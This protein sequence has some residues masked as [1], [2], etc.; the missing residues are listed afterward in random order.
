VAR[1]EIHLLILSFADVSGVLNDVNSSPGSSVSE[2]LDLFPESPLHRYLSTLR[3][4]YD[5]IGS[6]ECAFLSMEF[7]P[8]LKLKL[9]KKLFFRNGFLNKFILFYHIYP[10]FITSRF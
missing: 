1:R 10:I 9:V 2:G 8:Y 6:S 4:S 3:H 5:L 7:Y